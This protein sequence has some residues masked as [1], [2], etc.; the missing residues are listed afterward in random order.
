MTR[1][2]C[3]WTSQIA[4]S[5]EV[6]LHESHLRAQNHKNIFCAH[7]LIGYIGQHCIYLK[8][9]A[10]SPYASGVL[11][12]GGTQEEH[13]FLAHPAALVALIFQHKLQDDEAVCIIG[14]DQYTKLEYGTFTVLDFANMGAVKAADR[15]GRSAIT[16]IDAADYR[17]NPSA[18]YRPELITREL[19]KVSV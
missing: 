9:C 19:M 1:I 10:I 13:L 12:G 18:Q 7:I 5:V 14:A 4:S 2:I 16:A 17:D 11:G 6:S 3:R 15:W 8:S